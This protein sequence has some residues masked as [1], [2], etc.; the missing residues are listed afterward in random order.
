LNFLIDERPYSINAT[1]VSHTNNDIEN[2]AYLTVN[3]QSGFIAHFNC[4]WSSPVK[5]RM[6]LL[7]GD[8]KMMVYNDLEPTEKIRIYDTRYEH[9]TDEEKRKIMV[10]YRAGDVYIPMI[11]SKEALFGM[12]ADFLN[13]IINKTEPLSSYKSGLDVIKILEAS[14]K[15]IKQ[16][17]KEILID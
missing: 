7:G 3:Y 14:Q 13:S 5:I 15:S 10:E 11:D 4:S 8:E 17:G 1:G 12:A 16:N 2:I 9:T 6:M